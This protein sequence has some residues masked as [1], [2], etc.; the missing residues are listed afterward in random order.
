MYLNVLI[1][2]KNTLNSA[3]YDIDFFSSNFRVMWDYPDFAKSQTE[4]PKIQIQIP[5]FFIDFKTEIHN[6]KVINQFLQIVPIFG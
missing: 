1:T 5:F 3:Y 4:V 2:P 6:L